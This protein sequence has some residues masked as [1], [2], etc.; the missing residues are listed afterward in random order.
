MTHA[1]I[2]TELDAKNIILYIWTARRRLKRIHR[3]MV[4][5][6][7]IAF[8]Q[9]SHSEEWETIIKT[10]NV[11]IAVDIDSY[12]QIGSFA[13]IESRY[14]YHSPQHV[15]KTIYHT[16]LNEAQFDC[17]KQRIWVTKTKLSEKKNPTSYRIVK[18][19]E[20]AFRPY[21]QMDHEDEIASLV[22]QVQKMVG[23]Q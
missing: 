14:S 10:P 12:A 6:A 3:F 20:P 13:K 2:L 21:N 1:L 11:V 22:C 5:T 7:T 16:K 8:S 18:L 15:D 4:V 17:K 9:L 19:A 23:G